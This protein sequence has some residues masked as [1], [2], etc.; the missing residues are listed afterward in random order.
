M[1]LRQIDCF[2]AVATD[3]HFGKAA[4]RLSVAQSSVSEAIRALEHE[5]G[6]PLFVRTSRRVQL[7][8]LGEKL[9]RGVEPAA[10]VLRAT[11]EDCRKIA[12]NQSNRVRIGFVGGGLYDLTLPFIRHLK[13]K[14]Q[15]DVDWVE[16]SLLDQFEAVA[17]G[18]V[19]AAFCRLPLSHDGLVQC[20]VLFEN[21]R[22]LIVS[23]DHRLANRDLVDPEELALETLPTLPDNHQLG[24]WTAFHFPDHTPSGRP[25]DRGPVVETVREM[26]AVVKSGEVVALMSAAAERYYSDPGVRYIDIDVPPVGTALVRRRADR[27]RVILDLEECSRDVAANH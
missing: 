18:K 17:A 1:E 10:L 7:T 27:R 2:L 19:D 14:F 24:P 21:K 13:S 26:F 22:K 15:I 6:G 16:L 3:L 11:L 8:P 9:R 5:V 12:L 4:E 25:I 23:T 20:V